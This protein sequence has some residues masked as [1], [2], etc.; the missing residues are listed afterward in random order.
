MNQIASIVDISSYEVVIVGKHITHEQGNLVQYGKGF[1]WIRFQ[2]VTKHYCFDSIEIVILK[3]VSTFKSQ[4]RILKK[5][6]TLGA[7]GGEELPPGLH[8]LRM[9]SVWLAEDGP[10]TFLT[11]LG[12]YI[13]NLL[14]CNM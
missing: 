2:T 9:L 11:R 13:C 4:H 14:K 12:W 1:H 10:E 3:V 5:L 7:G 8:A 6:K